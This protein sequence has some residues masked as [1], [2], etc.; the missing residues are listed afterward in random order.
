MDAYMTVLRIIHIF[1]GV[2]WVGSTFMLAGY[3]VPAVEAA[4]DAGRA[5]MTQFSLKT[6]F[7]PAMGAAGI[8]S[9]LSGMLMYERIFGFRTEAFSSGYGIG[10]TIGAV[11][12]ILALIFGFVFQFYSIRKMKA[13]NQEVEA[14]GGPPSPEQLGELGHHAERVALGGRIG[15]ILMTIALLGMSTAQYLG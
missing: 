4:G 15:I 5:F 11:A 13:I 8:L 14:S 3:V 7:S 9:M 6:G 10:I 1:A 12:G 2:F